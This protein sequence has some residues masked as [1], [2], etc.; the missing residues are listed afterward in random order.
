MGRQVIESPEDWA[1]EQFGRCRLGDARR[2]RRTVRLAGQMASRPSAS[3]PSQTEKWSEAKAG[4]RLF[5]QEAVT[6]EATVEPHWD[7]VRQAAR[8]R[9]VVLMIEDTSELDFTSH[10]NAK[11]LGPIGNGGGRGFMLHSTLAVDPRGSGEV[12]GLGYQM[13]FCREAMSEAWK[14]RK[15]ETRTQRKRRQ[16]ESEIWP[17]SVRQIG[18]G[19]ERSRWVHVCD[20]YADNYEMFTA[21][22]RTEVDFVIRLS[23]DRRASLGHGSATARGNLLPL[24]RGLPAAGEQTLHVRRRPNRRAREAKLL[25][26]YSAVT[27]FRPW[28]DRSAPEQLEGSGVRVWE[29]DTPAGD[30]PIEWVVLTSVPIRS[31]SEALEI[32]RWYSLRWLIEEYHKCLKSGCKVEDRQLHEA[33]RLAPCVGILAVVAVRLL[34]LKLFAKQEPNRPAKQCVSALHVEVLGAYR[35]KDI[36]GLTAKEFFREVAKLGGFLGRRSD[37]DPGWQTLWR[38]W[39]KL[40]AMTLGASLAQSG[41]PRCG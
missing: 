29:A 13:L 4:Y 30:A 18:R 11:G 7:Q 2:T 10:L 14:Q 32:S 12:L 3:I 25:V 27:I 38:G 21:C 31:T 17:T 5:R 36:E 16:R 20:R 19:G 40:D 34:Q 33:E 6:F 8:L 9:D 41:L 22:K 35:K 37:G 39:Q 1:L 26:S 15:Q 28:L 24:V 23:Q